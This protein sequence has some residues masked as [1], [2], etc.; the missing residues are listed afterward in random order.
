MI[1]RYIQFYSCALLLLLGA[2]GLQAQSSKVEI[3][4]KVISTS[5]EAVEFATVMIG[6]P[7][8]QK[9]I[10]G[11][12]TKEDGSFLIKANTDNFFVEVS[13]IGY[14]SKRINEIE[15]VEG[16]LDLGTI[17]IAEDVQ[18]LDE[19]MVRAEKSSTEFKLDKRVFNVG[20]DLSSTGM[21]ALEIL[22]NVPSVTV[23]IE[24]AISLRGSS[25]V[26][27]L[28]NGKPS[29]L[30]QDQGTLGTLTSDMIEKIEVITNPSAKYDAEGTSG[31]INIVIKKEEKK[32]LNGSISLNTG[33][34]N[35]H[36]V[37]LSMNRRTEKF[38][39]FTQLGAGLRTY[40]QEYNTLNEDL[41]TNETITSVGSGKKNEIFYN[42]ILGADYH[43]NDN[44]VITLTGNYAFEDEED[45]SD[46]TFMR[47]DANSELEDAWDRNE[48]TTADNPKW[49]FE[50]NYKKDFKDHKD[51]DLVFTAQGHFFG[52]DQSSEFKNTT[53]Y[54]SLISEEQRTR[55]DFSDE[56][57][58]FKLDYTHPFSEQVKLEAGSQL[59]PMNVSND[60]AVSTLIGD[61]W[62]ESAELTN[63]FEFQQTV[64]GVYSTGSYEGERWGVKA[65]IRMEY[66]DVNTFLANTNTEN[67]KYYTNFFPSIHT[68][69][70]F[71]N[72]FSLQAGYSQRIYRPR[73]W[74]LNPFFNIRNNF[75]IRTGNPELMPEYTDAFEVTGIYDLAKVSFNVGAYHRYTTDVIERV[76]TSE[77]NISVSKPVN[78]G[79]NRT[80][81]IEFNAKYDATDWLSF[82]G[83]LNINYFIRKG[84]YEEVSFDFD[85]NQF[86]SRVSAKLK[87]PAD[88][89]MELHG[90]YRS[91]LQTVQSLVSETYFM[92]FGVRKKLMKGRTILNLSVRDVFATRIRESVTDQASF[93]LYSYQQRGRFITF[94]ISYGFGKGEAMEFSGQRRRR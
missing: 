89:E 43:I 12:T 86:T 26:Q 32:G 94:G 10:T 75:N 24:G 65:G 63:I 57:Y 17:T 5:N 51:H 78:V 2:N 6:D 81:G 62:V 76:T 4:G 11:T 77:N 22:N 74:D 80:T 60:Y 52:K 29:V 41:I 34:P 45:L 59:V 84:L 92:D 25:G 87:L 88:F 13:F 14:T 31:I 61:E 58:T 64:L 70:K 71:T 38:N 91:Q 39:L 47:Y 27:I 49:Q 16:K 3:T 15:V 23:D 30:A 7:Q 55:T 85:N 67:S 68:S 48:V 79:S 66:T 36:S 37:G 1:H 42:L 40:P 69:Y 19:V 35:S 44:N 9:P 18:A 21:S 72:M 82:N 93:Y 8:T 33:T 20:Q 56:T 46:A 83:D 50:M 28:I 90:N 73:M 54:G 53:T